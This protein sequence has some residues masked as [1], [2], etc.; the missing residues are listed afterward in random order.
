MDNYRNK[1]GDLAT[2]EVQR[3][4]Y[5]KYFLT[6]HFGRLGGWPA[7]FAEPDLQIARAIVLVLMRLAHD[8]EPERREGR[9]HLRLSRYQPVRGES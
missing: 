7:A 1:G 4:A 2:G 5:G 3:T 8:F 9:L 6:E